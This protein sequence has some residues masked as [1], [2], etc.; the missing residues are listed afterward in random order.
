VPEASNMQE[1]IIGRNQY[2]Q[3]VKD[4]FG[5]FPS[6]ETVRGYTIGS[7][8]TT[9]QIIP[10]DK[11]IIVSNSIN[12]NISR[13]P[14]IRYSSINKMI[15]DLKSIVLQHI[16][17][18]DLYETGMLISAGF[19]SQLILNLL[20]DN[21]NLKNNLRLFS[22]RTLRGSVVSE[23]AETV[24]FTKALGYRT[25]IPIDLND[26][27]LFRYEIE[28]QKRRFIDSTDG[29]N[30]YACLSEI[31]VIA[32]LVRVI[33]TGAGGD[34][35]SGGYP[36]EKFAF[37]FNLVRPE[38]LYKII[39]Y[40][41]YRKLIW[42]FAFLSRTLQYFL[43]R[44]TFF[45]TNKFEKF[46]NESTLRY[47]EIYKMNTRELESFWYLKNQLLR[48]SNVI[49]GILSFDVRAPLADR[50]VVELF[51]AASEALGGIN[52]KMFTKYIYNFK[53]QKTK[54]SFIVEKIR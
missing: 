7:P 28:L 11:R 4:L 16:P 37:G 21:K 43:I 24:E 49:G 50:R 12:I 5:F 34:E 26:K 48:D 2:S 6:G 41:H 20:S 40:F 3:N 47:S 36:S 18:T 32:P 8:G 22:L 10:N 23:W 52:R 19:D 38:Q 51:N 17:N 53:Y 1:V 35:V 46:L 9:Y 30:L 15:A 25:P 14:E 31:R 13:V 45:N 44:A 39:K 54:Q 29:L 33:L 27:T 42:L